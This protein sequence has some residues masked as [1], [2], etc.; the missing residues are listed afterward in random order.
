ML[1]QPAPKYRAF[2]G[3]QPLDRKWPARPLPAAPIW[4]SGD[5]RDGT[6]SLFEP[7]NAERNLRMSPPLCEVASSR[8]RW[9]SPAPRKPSLTLCAA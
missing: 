2:A 6:Q 7:M 1:A 9:P 8:S 4:M 3:F 5:L